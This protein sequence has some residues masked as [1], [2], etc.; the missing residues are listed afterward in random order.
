MLI[1]DKVNTIFVV[2]SIRQSDKASDYFSPEQ[3]LTI[4][5]TRIVN[6]KI[7]REKNGCITY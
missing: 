5:L 3:K 1:R 7:S 2:A 4:R 6:D